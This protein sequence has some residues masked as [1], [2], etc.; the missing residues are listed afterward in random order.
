MGPIARLD[1]VVDIAC[2]VNKRNKKYKQNLLRGTLFKSPLE[3]SI[4]RWEDN[5]KVCRSEIASDY[6]GR[7]RGGDLRL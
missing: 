7:I 3:I 6:V 2:S 5:I 4:Q 1:T